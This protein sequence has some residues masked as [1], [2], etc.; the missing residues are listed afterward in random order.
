MPPRFSYIIPTRDRHRALLHTLDAIASIGDHAPFGGAE[1]VIAD[2][3]SKEPLR[4]PPH[5]PISTRIIRLAENNGAAARNVAASQARGEWLVM[6]DDDSAP[7]DLRFTDAVNTLL[8]G[9][10]AVMADIFLPN[11]DGTPG[12]R[13][14]GGLPEVPVGCG[15]MYRRDAFLGLGGYDPAFLYYAEEYDFAARFIAAGKRV[16]FDPRFRVLHR[17]IAAG[18]DMNLIL[19]L[20]VRN[21]GWVNE[22]YTPQARRAEERSSLLRRYA[23][24]AARENAL[25]G[26]TQGLRELRATRRHQPDAALSD[27][28][29]AR[30]TGLAHARRAISAHA[31][32]LHLRR[33]ALTHPGKNAHCVR[34]AIEERGIDI[35]PEADAQALVIATLSPGPMLDA[36]A[37]LRASRLPVIAPWLDAQPAAPSASRLAA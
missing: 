13:E 27:E 12:P 18:R 35:V 24:I 36:V 8:P 16:V 4:L 14:Q 37:S 22:R 30:F 29:F 3:A 6:L 26:F 19:S 17:K 15:V 11:A 5:S 34:A 25:P 2:N 23:A 9:V 33:V 1:I 10:D 21:N 31:D 7:L 32:A 20:L 28:R